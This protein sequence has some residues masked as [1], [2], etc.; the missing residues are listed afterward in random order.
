MFCGS[1]QTRIDEKVN[2]SIKQSPTL[3]LIKWGI[4]WLCD[5]HGFEQA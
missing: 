3:L 1:G 5:R 2:S 4:G